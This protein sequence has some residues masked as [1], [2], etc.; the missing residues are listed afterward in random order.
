M[1]PRGDCTKRPIWHTGP[2]QRVRG[3][4]VS[5]MG[6]ALR[7]WTPSP[8]FP[9]AKVCRASAPSLGITLPEDDTAD[10]HSVLPDVVQAGQL[11]TI[12]VQTAL[13]RVLLIV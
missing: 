10:G 6:P 7:A 5:E 4:T 13:I 8:P 2:D 9:L 3:L 11:V 1:C 12:C